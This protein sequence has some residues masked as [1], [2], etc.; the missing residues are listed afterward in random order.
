MSSALGFFVTGYPDLRGVLNKTAT[1]DYLPEA[2]AGPCYY[3]D[4]CEFFNSFTVLLK[5]KA[6]GTGCSLWSERYGSDAAKNVMRI[7]DGREYTIT[8]S[9]TYSRKT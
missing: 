8:N 4:N 5:D 2:C 7:I 9:Q 1:S 6:V 3:D